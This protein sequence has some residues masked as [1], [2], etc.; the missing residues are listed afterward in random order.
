MWLLVAAS[1]VC[2][3]TWSVAPPKLTRGM[4]TG[5]KAL[6]RTAMETPPRV[7]PLAGSMLSMSGSA[8]EVVCRWPANEFCC[9]ATVTTHERSL[10]QPAAVSHAMRVWSTSSLGSAQAY[11]APVQ[12]YVTESSSASLAKLKPSSTKRCAPVDSASFAP[13]A[14]MLLMFGSA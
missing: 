3:S 5:P 9:P 4:P 13:G 6:P 8:Y 11:S 7:G 2:S 1:I 14:P 10:P 12:P